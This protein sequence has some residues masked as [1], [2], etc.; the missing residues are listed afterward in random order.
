MKIKKIHEYLLQVLL[1]I[2]LGSPMV[3]GLMDV[4]SS[5]GVMIYFSILM[6][7][8]TIVGNHYKKEREIAEEKMMEYETV[9]VD[10]TDD[11]F[12]EASDTESSEQRRRRK[13]FCV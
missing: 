4:T 12:D 2:F 10:Q 11:S 1:M 8:F 9:L 7:C 6:I 5:M 13:I 3:S